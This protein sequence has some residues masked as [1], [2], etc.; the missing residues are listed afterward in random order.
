[1]PWRPWQEIRWR[2]M[3]ISC[4]EEAEIELGDAALCAPLDPVRHLMIGVATPT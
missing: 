2:D 4:A 1:L 3:L